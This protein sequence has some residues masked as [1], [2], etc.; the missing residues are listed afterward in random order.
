MKTYALEYGE[1]EFGLHVQPVDYET[2]NWWLTAPD[3]SLVQAQTWDCDESAVLSDIDLSDYS[4][5]MLR[6][7]R[8]DRWDYAASQWGI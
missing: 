6:T 1:V 2:T 8:P 3:G 5:A 4:W 7:E